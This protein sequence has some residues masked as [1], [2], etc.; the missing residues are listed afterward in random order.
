MDMATPGM[1]GG[2]RPMA[3]DVIDPSVGFRRTENRHARQDFVARID[4]RVLS[5]S[6]ACRERGIEA[7]SARVPPLIL[8]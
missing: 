3:A 7:R 6:A 1:S 5:D 8:S 4:A 2:P